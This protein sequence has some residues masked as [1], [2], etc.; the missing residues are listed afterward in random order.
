MKIQ[1]TDVG[2]VCCGGSL[3]MFLLYLTTTQDAVDSNE[4]G[5]TQTN[6]EQ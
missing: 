2:A 5:D 3:V 4:G 1:E 6:D